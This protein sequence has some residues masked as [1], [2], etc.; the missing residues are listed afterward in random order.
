VHEKPLSFKKHI[1]IGNTGNI[2]VI[3]RFNFCAVGWRNNSLFLIDVIEASH[4]WVVELEGGAISAASALS[5]DPAP[6]PTL[7]GHCNLGGNIDGSKTSHF[8]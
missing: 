2:I 6:G 1:F 3:V 8:L 5:P 7:S 4:K